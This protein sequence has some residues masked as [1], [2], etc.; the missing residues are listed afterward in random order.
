MVY[1]DT[2]N[3]MTGDIYTFDVA[4][5]FSHTAD[6]ITDFRGN[7]FNI[8]DPQDP[9]TRPKFYIGRGLFFGFEK[10]QFVEMSDTSLLPRSN[11]ESLVLWLRPEDD[12]ATGANVLTHKSIPSVDTELSAELFA[13]YYD[14]V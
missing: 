14:S 8:G 4:D 6:T 12:G 13:I 10:N 7:I 5:D 9:S 3:S 11:S 1:D 2:T